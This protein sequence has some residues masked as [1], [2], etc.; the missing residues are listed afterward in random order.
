[1]GWGCRC[2]GLHTALNDLKR[3]KHLSTHNFHH[4][5]RLW[6]GEGMHIM[7]LPSSLYIHS[8][9]LNS[10]CDGDAAPN[11][12]MLWFCTKSGVH[13]HLH[14]VQDA[15]R[16]HS[17]VTAPRLVMKFSL[18]AE[19]VR[20]S[21]PSCVHAAT[22]ASSQ[23]Y[24]LSESWTCSHTIQCDHFC[25]SVPALRMGEGCTSA[26]TGMLLC[27]RFLL[28][29]PGGCRSQAVTDTPISLSFRAQ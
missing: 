19:G 29:P 23:S 18:Q 8:R 14:R 22:T 2:Y 20:G 6:V 17:G 27:H 15:S 13:I 16:K 11:A 5:C 10:S 9:R 26:V 12:H 21:L 1:M 24:P 28:W 3:R 25:K 7:H 4:A